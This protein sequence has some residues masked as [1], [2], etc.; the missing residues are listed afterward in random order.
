MLSHPHCFSPGGGHLPHLLVPASFRS[1]VDPAPIS[2]PTWRCIFGWVFSQPTG[3]PAVGLNQID[4][5]RL[6]FG[7]RVAWRKPLSAFI[8]SP[9]ADA[10]RLTP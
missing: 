3:H 6:F 10:L 4:I 7:A 8:G 5:T 2:R 1:E 9:S